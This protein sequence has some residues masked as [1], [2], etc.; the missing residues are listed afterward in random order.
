[1]PKQ[2]TDSQKDEK[3]GSE[4]YAILMSDGKTNTAY[5]LGKGK[6]LGQH[7]APTREVSSKLELENGDI[8]WGYEVWWDFSPKLELVLGRLEKEGWTIKTVSIVEY[9]K[10][11]LSLFG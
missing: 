7:L 4:I 9:R 1:M 11:S 8:V 10:R 6:Y 5:V 2:N 3:V